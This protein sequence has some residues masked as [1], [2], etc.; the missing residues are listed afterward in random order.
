LGKLLRKFKDSCF[1]Q[2]ISTTGLNRPRTRKEDEDDDD[3]DDDD[4]DTSTEITILLI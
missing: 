3:D 1:V 4:D 2:V